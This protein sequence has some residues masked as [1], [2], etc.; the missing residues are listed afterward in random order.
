M[1]SIAFRQGASNWT[2]SIFFYSEMCLQ[3]ASKRGM[4]SNVYLVLK[5]LSCSFSRTWQVTLWIIDWRDIIQFHIFINIFHNH[6]IIYTSQNL[7]MPKGRLKTVESIFP[8]EMSLIIIYGLIYI[9]HIFVISFCFSKAIYFT[10][11]SDRHYRIFFFLKFPLLLQRQPS[12][13]QLGLHI[14][15]EKTNDL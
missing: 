6:E 8:V 7:T 15:T 10:K 3:V 14:Y 11:Y 12:L 1:T 9:M 2:N 13:L 4:S 5:S